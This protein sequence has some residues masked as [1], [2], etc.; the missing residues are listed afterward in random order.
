MQLSILATRDAKAQQRIVIA[1]EKL[2][3]KFGI[4]ANVTVRP[5]R[6][7]DPRV[8]AMQQREEVAD[9]LEALLGAAPAADGIPLSELESVPGVGPSTMAKIREHLGV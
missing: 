9:L 7:K 3:K 5:G 1:A 6:A 8:A 4:E 2:A